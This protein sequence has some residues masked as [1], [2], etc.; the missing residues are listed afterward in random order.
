MSGVGEGMGINVVSNVIFKCLEIGYHILRKSYL[1]IDEAEKLKKR[2][3]VQI[4]ILDAIG[5]KMQNPEIRNRLREVDVK[6]YIDILQQFHCLLQKYVERKCQPGPEKIQLLSTTSLDELLK[7]LETDDGWTRLSSQKG[8]GQKFWS[9]V[10]EEASWTVWGKAKEEKII[11]EIE[12]W[13]NQLDKF[14]S[15]TIPGMFFH[16]T[17]AEITKNVSDARLNVTNFKSDIMIARSDSIDAGASSAGISSFEIRFGQ[18]EGI[19]GAYVHGP[20]SGPVVG[21]S[22][23]SL[24]QEH[25]QWAQFREIDGQTSKV[26]IDF[27]VRDDTFSYIDTNSKKTELNHLV[28]TL[29]IAV[30]KSDM[31]RVLYCHG[32]YEAFDHYGLVFRPPTENLRCESLSNIL[33]QEKLRILLLQD[34]ENRV[35]LAQALAWTTLELHSVDW[36]HKSLNPDNI[37]LF[38]EEIGEGSIRFDWSSPYLVGFGSSRSNTGVSDQQ[39]GDQIEFGTRIYL[40]PDRQLKEYARYQKIHDM[41]S[42][43][44]VLLEIGQ[45]KLLRESRSA[46]RLQECSPHQLKDTFVKKAKALKIVLG[47]RFTKAVVTCLTGNFSIDIP[48]QDDYLLLSSF[49]SD[50]CQ[51]LAEIEV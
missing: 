36:V 22:Q 14:S 16:S 24:K 15:W 7:K 17:I 30:Q 40:H 12:Y 3:Q 42:L 37:L 35:R 26:L 4:A 49:R 46:S 19:N 48:E 8:N 1:Y 13:G 28:Q 38:G 44:I 45:L 20:K 6:T 39:S 47:K 23:T 9:K 41:Y 34:I 33:L 5:L 29:R 10:K 25:R 43:G 31:F 21:S 51:T 11:Y 2:L 32:W 18:V 50:V 27:K